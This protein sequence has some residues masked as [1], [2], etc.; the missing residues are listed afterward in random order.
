[1]RRFTTIALSLCLLA[2]G[3][4]GGPRESE[5]TTAADTPEP[6]PAD[7]GQP[8][9]GGVAGTEGDSVPAEPTTTEPRPAEGAEPQPAQAG[10]EPSEPSTGTG[11]EMHATEPSGGARGGP[12]GASDPSG[13]SGASGPAE[14][15]DGWAGS[16]DAT[17]TH[18]RVS[19]PCPATPRQTG[20]ATIEQRGSRVTLR[21]VSGFRCRPASACRFTGTASGG[22]VTLSNA[23][24]A[25]DEGGTFST[26]MVLRRSGAGLR[27]E[28]T[29]TYRMGPMRC[30]WE[31][32][33]ELR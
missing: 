16:Y 25:D 23:G 1:M 30:R 11:E 2:V 18:R 15:G 7:E 13:A 3:A 32:T 19:G 31:T 29:S 26:E 17:L 28:G 4:C 5:P 6:E 27:A 10:V 33:L 20:R 12:E 9:S 21:L 8:P 22:R 14:G 24:A